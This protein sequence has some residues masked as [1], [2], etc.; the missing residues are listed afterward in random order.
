MWKPKSFSSPC[1]CVTIPFRPECVTRSSGSAISESRLGRDNRR[2]QSDVTAIVTTTRALVKLSNT[3]HQLYSASWASAILGDS[4]PRSS[5]GSG[6][7]FQCVAH[8]ST[9]ARFKILRESLRR[10]TSGVSNLQSKGLGMVSLESLSFFYGS[11][12]DKPKILCKSRAAWRT[13]T[14]WRGLVLYR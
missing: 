7:I 14:I 8:G 3:D 2:A 11:S 5:Y 9:V 4:M 6:I 1:G 10:T 13:R 12:S